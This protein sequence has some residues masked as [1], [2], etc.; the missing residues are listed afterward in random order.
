MVLYFNHAHRCSSWARPPEALSPTYLPGGSSSPTHKHFIFP[1]LLLNSIESWKFPGVSVSLV[2]PSGSLQLVWAIRQ[3]ARERERLEAGV[4]GVGK[5]AVGNSSTLLSKRGVHGPGF[6]SK[7]L[8]RAPI[9]AWSQRWP[10]VHPDYSPQANSFL[11]SADTSETLWALCI[12]C[13]KRKMQWYKIPCLIFFLQVI[14]DFDDNR[15]LWP[16]VSYLGA[17]IASRK[18]QEILR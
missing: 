7:T 14:E 15:R 8:A 5:Y 10:H 16:K 13:I 6:T 1:D 11:I 12:G 2:C 3:Q 9:R 18:R 17:N 4:S